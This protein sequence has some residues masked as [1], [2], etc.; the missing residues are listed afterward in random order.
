MGQNVGRNFVVFL[1]SPQTKE[2]LPCKVMVGFASPTVV[3]QNEL[4]LREP[5]LVHVCGSRNLSVLPQARLRFHKLVCGYA[6]RLERRSIATH[7]IEIDSANFVCGSYKAST[8][9]LFC[10][11]WHTFL[12]LLP[13]AFFLLFRVF[14]G[15]IFGSFSVAKVAFGVVTL[16]ASKT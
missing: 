9:D 8:R 5:V 11:F 4:W 7:A 14:C 12:G 2:T 16:D 1:G 15:T 3:P 6:N 10:F 13:R